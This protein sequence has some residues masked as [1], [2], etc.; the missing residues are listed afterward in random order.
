[1]QAKEIGIWE[2]K[3]DNEYNQE[4]DREEEREIVK[5]N[6]EKWCEGEKREGEME[7]R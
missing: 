4:E 7:E 5:I 1:M 2:V 6:R 3:R